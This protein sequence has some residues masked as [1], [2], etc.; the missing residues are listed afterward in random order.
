MMRRGRSPRQM[1]TPQMDTPLDDTLHTTLSWGMASQRSFYVYFYFYG[2]PST[3]RGWRR[4]R[5]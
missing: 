4:S 5:D 3:G 2:R 1:D